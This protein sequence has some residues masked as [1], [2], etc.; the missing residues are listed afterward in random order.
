MQMAG[1][2]KKPATWMNI[3]RTLKKYKS[4]KEQKNLSEKSCII[5]VCQSM[6]VTGLQSTA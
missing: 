4:S 1:L 3:G 5:K 6:N 2:F